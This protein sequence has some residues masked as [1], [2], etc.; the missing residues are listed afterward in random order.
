[1][2]SIRLSFS[3]LA[4]ICSLVLGLIRA[5]VLFLRRLIYRIA[6]FCLGGHFKSFRDKLKY[7]GELVQCI[8]NN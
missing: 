2:R 5:E 8:S 7:F 4:A 1:M 3:L 6:Q